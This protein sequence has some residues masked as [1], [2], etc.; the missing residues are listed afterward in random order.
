MTLVPNRKGPAKDAARAAPKRAA[1]AGQYCP[2]KALLAL[3]GIATSLA[4]AGLVLLTTMLP[5][6]PR[7][8]IAPDGA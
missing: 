2:D 1:R 3:G 7:P 5:M 4:G 8:R 6:V